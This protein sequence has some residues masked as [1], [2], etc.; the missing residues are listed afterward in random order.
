MIRESFR[1]QIAEHP[2]DVD[3]DLGDQVDRAL[4]VD[5]DV[6]SEPRHLQIAGTDD[7]LDGRGEK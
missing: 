2:F 1:N 7:S 5:L 6:V 3:V 4:H